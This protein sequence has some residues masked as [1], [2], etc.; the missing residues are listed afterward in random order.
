[1]RALL[2]TSLVTT[3]AVAGL[4]GCANTAGRSAHADAAAGDSTRAANAAK[5]PSPP[6][7]LLPGEQIDYA[8]HRCGNPNLHVKTHLCLYPR[9]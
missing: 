7:D 8:G 4:G 6:T 5:K 9:R 3:L 1:M 2:L